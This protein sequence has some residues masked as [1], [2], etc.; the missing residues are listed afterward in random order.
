MQNIQI[1]TIKN[2]IKLY[3]SRNYYIQSTSGAS[4]PR[5]ARLY[6]AARFIIC[7]LCTYY[8]NC[9]II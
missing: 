5:S 9:T 6:Y 1:N 3:I 4:N 2:I 8:Q 7:K